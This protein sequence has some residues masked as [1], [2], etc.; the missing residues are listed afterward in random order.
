MTFNDGTN[1]VQSV[2]EPDPLDVERREDQRG[3][4]AHREIGEQRQPELSVPAAK[5]VMLK[6]DQGRPMG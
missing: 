4:G 1:R 5:I 6:K 2:T 3:S